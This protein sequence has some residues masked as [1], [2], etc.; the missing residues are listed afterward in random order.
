MV[1]TLG[2]HAKLSLSMFSL[3]LLAIVTNSGTFLQTSLAATDTHIIAAGDWHCTEDAAKAVN[4]AQSLKPQLVL[5]LGDY[6]S[7]GTESCWVNLSKPVDSITKIAIGN[8][9]NEHDGLA[10]AYLNHYGLSKQFYSFDIKNVHV[11]TMATE[12]EFKPGSEQYNFVVND[13]RNSANNPNIKWII[14]TM[15]NPVYT[16]PNGCSDSSCE[17]DEE[18]SESYHPLF[19]K[20]GVD[21]VLQ[22]HVRNYQ[23]SFPLEFNQESPSNPTVTSTSKAEYKNPNGAIFAIVGTG[24]GEL[25]HELEGASPFMAF[26]QDTKFGILDMHFSDNSLNAKFVAN[27]GSTMDQFSLSKTAKKKVIER[28]SDDAFSDTNIRAVSDKETANAVPL[29]RQVAQDGKPSITF[30]L[31][32]VATAPNTDAKLAQDGKPSITFKF[33]EAAS[34][35]N[36]KH[37][38]LAGQEFQEVKPA[39]KTNPDDSPPKDDKP[40]LLSEEQVK[41]EQVKPAVKTNRDDSPPKDDS[42][43][44]SLDEEKVNSND[45]AK[46]TSFQ[47][48]DKVDNSHVQDVLGSLDNSPIADEVS[49]TDEK[50]ATNTNIMD[51]FAALNE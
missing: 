37:D 15:H 3:L 43:P 45:N 12:V 4:I 23:R 44:M 46:S 51:P 5:G 34:S 19:D 29:A 16:S 30:K 48:N 47:R 38:P 20:Y 2:I 26:Q 1:Q 18:L 7:T 33:D 24:G 10:N 28:I 31:D 41:Q 49:D 40:M 25:K 6:S 17:S 50:K 21:I 39:V 32:E 36:S 27:D 8:H 9:D 11:L 42:K 22:A 13:L 14:V 35:T